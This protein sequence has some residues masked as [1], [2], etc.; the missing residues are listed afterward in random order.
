M[1]ASQPQSGAFSSASRSE[2]T[3][4][5]ISTAPTHV[6]RAVAG[7]RR[8]AP[9]TNSTASTSAVRAG[10]RAE[11]ERRRGVEVL[12]DEAGDRVAEPDARPHPR[13]TGSRSS[14]SPCRAAGDRARRPSSAASARGR[15]PASRGRRR[16]GRASWRAPRAPR[17]AVT[18]ASAETS[19][20]AAVRA[21]AEAAEQRRG[22]GADQQRRGQRP[23]RRA[24]AGVQVAGDRRDQRRAERA[25]HRDDE[26][27]GDQRGHVAA[28]TQTEVGDCEV[29]IEVM[30]GRRTE[31]GMPVPEDTLP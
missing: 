11:P 15:G 18:T 2:R 22:D 6:E 10:Q 23:L 25:D 19:T 13:P 26:A 9:G 16:A 28:R 1:V 27:D 20:R 21:V 12:G 8:R 14:W 5:P 7:R 30:V 24:E 29:V 17:R 4:P 31:G 3:P